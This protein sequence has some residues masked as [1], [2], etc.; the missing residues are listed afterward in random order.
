MVNVPWTRVIASDVFDICASFG[1]CACCMRHK[2]NFDFVP[3]FYLFI[4]IK[5]QEQTSDKDSTDEY[6][7]S[8]VSRIF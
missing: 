8:R 7:I 3:T 1:C 2:W 5:L 4:I 6:L